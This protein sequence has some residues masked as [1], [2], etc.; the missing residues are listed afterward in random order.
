ML[1]APA[2]EPRAVLRASGP[3]SNPL[4]EPKFQWAFDLALTDLSFFLLG[5]KVHR[6][7]RSSAQIF[8]PTFTLPLNEFLTPASP[9][10][11]T[12]NTAFE[13]QRG[14]KFLHFGG[15]LPRRRRRWPRWSLRCCWARGTGWGAFLPRGQ[16]QRPGPLHSRA[17]CVVSAHRACLVVVFRFLGRAFL[18][19]APPARASPG[20]RPPL[21]ASTRRAR[22]SSAACRASILSC[23][24]LWT[25]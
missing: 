17:T 18:F 2:R 6:R 1:M 4:R 8:E 3:R 7:K 25:L 15:L 12:K 11:R 20:C 23:S 22:S 10:T 5:H 19:G 16:A 24:R 9:R 14:G 21:I 13:S